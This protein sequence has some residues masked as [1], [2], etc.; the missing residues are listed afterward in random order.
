MPVIKE[1]FSLRRN[2]VASAISS[3]FPNLPMGTRLLSS[4][5]YKN[6]YKQ[7]NKHTISDGNSRNIGVSTNVGHTA[8]TRIPWRAYYHLLA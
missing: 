8:L 7:K 6:K 5:V 4:E 1:D 3:T 2:K